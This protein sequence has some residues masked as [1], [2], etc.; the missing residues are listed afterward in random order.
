MQIIYV[1]SL[2]LLL[3]TFI[4]IKKSNKKLD[5][6]GFIPIAIVIM[7]CYNTF[8][9]Y[10]LTFF[11]MKCTL[12]NLSII[13]FIFTIC[14]LIA[15]TKKKQI[16]TYEMR[17]TDLIYIALIAISVLAISYKNFGIPFNV[18]YET[19]DPS[20][21]YLTS[22]MFAEQDS[23]LGSIPDEVYGKLETRKTASYVNSGLL[24]KILCPELEAMDCYNVFVCFGM[25][26]LFLTGW[27]FY[28]ALMNF[29]KGKKMQFIA[30]VITIICIMGY[31]LNS[32]LFG[33][34]YLSMALLIICA[35]LNLITIYEEKE[36]NIFFSLAIFALINFGLFSAYYMFVPFIYPAFGLYFLIQSYIKNKK[37]IT[38]ENIAF[39][40]ITLIIPFILG[41]IYH[42]EPQ[43]YRV[44]INQ[45]INYD[46]I[47]DYSSRILNKGLAVDGYIYINLYS[48][49]LI[50][51]PLAIYL[52]I[53]HIK[54]NKFNALAVGLCVAFI[55]ILLVGY[56]FEKVSIYY[57]SKNYF[58]LWILLLY[59]N[60]KALVKLNEKDKIIPI[61][62][63]FGYVV[64]L[65]VYLV[66][67]NT[68]ME[69]VLFNKD[70]TI[71]SVVEVFGA[72]KTILTKKQEQFNQNEIAILMYAKENLDKT[73][74]IE[75]VADPKP[76]YWAYVLLR[77]FN[78]EDFT[79]KYS[80]QQRLNAKLYKLKDNI[81]NV[82]YV[83]YFNK[84]KEYNKYK[85]RLFN[86]S[87]IIYEN[88]AGGIIKY[89]K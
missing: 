22:V 41:Y 12:L 25:F 2:I 73:T 74:K 23:L 76:Y 7:F 33:F 13:N 64:I 86:N 52:F 48:N 39:L 5:I 53:K 78:H 85:D 81:N 40:T 49:M 56:K 55:E 37:I 42:L 24:M 65:G 8:I 3:V 28:S 21:H 57:L 47:M 34:E 83:I 80:G 84:S 15:I 11:T 17:K 14:M 77:Y 1:L 59:C 10:V 75:V 87:K 6:I 66:F 67:S 19:S 69:D 50:L 82:D 18:K 68:K 32:F 44:I 61:I 38:K 45:N 72:N 70:E 9:C 58:A 71:F 54:E 63:T 36:M 4:L 46:T 20:V 35:L 51:L 26:I 62:C 27:T 43:I 88:E 89:E 79:Y 60:F 31:P 30:W 29:A 16:Q